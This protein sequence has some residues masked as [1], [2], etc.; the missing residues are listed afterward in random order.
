MCPAFRVS[1]PREEGV[2]QASK[3]L[4]YRVLLGAEELAD[5][6]ASLPS[7]SL[8]NVSEIVKH[9]EGTFSKEMFL[10]EYAAYIEA[11]KRGSVYTLPKAL[12]SCALSATPEAFYA[13]DVKK[14]IILKILKPVVQLSLHHFTYTPM[15]QSFHWMVHSQESVSWGLQFSYPQLYSNSMKGDVVELMKQQEDPNTCLFRTLMKWMRRNSRPIPF[16]I[17]GKRV[18]VEARLGETCFDWINTHPHLQEKN[19]IIQ[20]AGT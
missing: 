3:W 18:N 6:F 2:F 9:E 17:E 8:Y 11:L 13:M 5:L 12:F 14:G 19:L 20:R 10:S 15:N 16:F 1:H 4:T 7:F